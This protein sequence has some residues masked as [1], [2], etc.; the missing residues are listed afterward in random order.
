[1][2]TIATSMPSAE[3]P[4]IIPATVIAFAAEIGLRS[5]I[6]CFAF[7]SGA[8]HFLLKATTCAA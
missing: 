8:G 1:M 4:L 2:R 6:Y 3:V 5:G 7:I